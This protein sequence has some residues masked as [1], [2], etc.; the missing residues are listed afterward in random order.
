M[1]VGPFA[2]AARARRLGEGARIGNFV[3][4]KEAVIAA[5]AKANKLALGRRLGRRQSDVGT[6]PITCN[7]MAPPSATRPSARMRSSAPIPLWSRRSKSATAPMWLPGS[8]I[9]GNVPADALALAR[10]R[11]VVKEKWATRLR[12]L[13]SLGEKKA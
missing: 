2:A 4:I 9:T 12:S 5:G 11:Q 3:E 7:Q 1:L 10:A 13:K 6:A 8:V